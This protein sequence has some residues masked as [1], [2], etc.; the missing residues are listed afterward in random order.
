M[1]RNAIVKV[2]QAVS[3]KYAGKGTIREIDTGYPGYL[4]IEL[5]DGSFEYWKVKQTRIK[6]GI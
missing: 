5:A 4:L 1:S 3:H 2:G 6:V